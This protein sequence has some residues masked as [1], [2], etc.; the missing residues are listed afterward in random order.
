MRHV[1]NIDQHRPFTAT[2][3]QRLLRSIKPD[4]VVHELAY[5]DFNDFEKNIRTQLAACGRTPPSGGDEGG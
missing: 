2:A 1:I 4:Y 3:V 5:T